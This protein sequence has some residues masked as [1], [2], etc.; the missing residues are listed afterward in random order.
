MTSLHTVVKASASKRLMAPPDR[1][2]CKMRVD[3]CASPGRDRRNHSR[4]APQQQEERARVAACSVS[5]RH[6]RF[7]SGLSRGE[8]E[9]IPR[10]MQQVVGLALWRLRASCSPVG[11]PAGE[12]SIGN[13]IAGCPVMLNN[14]VSRSI[15]FRTGSIRPPATPGFA[16]A[17][18]ND[19]QGWQHQGVE[20]GRG[21]VHFLP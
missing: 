21:G 15:T 16:D 12:A 11:R 4:V 19:G 1:R 3:T 2:R 9:P 7:R 5:W 8:R 17:R 20:T 10:A 18:R 13:E 14:C 6:A